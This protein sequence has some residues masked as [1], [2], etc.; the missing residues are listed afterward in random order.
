VRRASLGIAAQSTV[1]PRRYL[2][3]FDLSSNKGVRITE[4]T[5]SGPAAGAGLE[6]GDVIV[7]FDRSPCGGVDDLHRLLSFERIDKP[8]VLTVLRRD[9]KL[10]LTVTP[11]KLAS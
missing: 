6:A 8:A 5:R 2:H 1:L 4:V 11:V 3:F 7:A 9:R 10:E